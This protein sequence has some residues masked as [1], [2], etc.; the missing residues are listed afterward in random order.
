MV[1]PVIFLM[2]FINAAALSPLRSPLLSLA[3]E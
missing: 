3:D 1:P 2:L